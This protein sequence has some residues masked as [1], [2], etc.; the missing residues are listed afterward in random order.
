M[1]D[2]HSTLPCNDDACYLSFSIIHKRATG[3]RKVL[4]STQSRPNSSL[5]ALLWVLCICASSQSHNF[6][7]HQPLW[8]SKQ[9][10]DALTIDGTLSLVGPLGVAEQHVLGSVCAESGLADTSEVP[11]GEGGPAADCSRA[12]E[13]GGGGDVGGHS[14][15]LC[16][17]PSPLTPLFL[18]LSCFHC[19]FV[20]CRVLHCHSDFYFC[21]NH[22]PLLLFKKFWCWPICALI[23]WQFCLLW[24]LDFSFFLL[25][26]G[27][28][29][30]YCKCF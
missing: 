19:A 26:F 4:I 28:F 27:D 23:C 5:Q 15:W 17:S 24:L 3:W 8:T 18:C 20:C 6:D 14:S 22:L 21:F 16:F 25:H 29:W 7:T 12:R 10:F 30:K 9:Q 11:P 2:A 1:Y 13:T